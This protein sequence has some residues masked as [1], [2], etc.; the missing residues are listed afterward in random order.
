MAAPNCSQE[1]HGRNLPPWIDL[2]PFV[3]AREQPVQFVPVDHAPRPY[4]A[5]VITQGIRE[6]V[7]RDWQAARDNK[8]AYWA[9]R[10]AHLG[11]LEAFR[12][13]DEVRRMF[14]IYVRVWGHRLV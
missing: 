2:D 14:R 4:K 13:A 5:R 11:P 9:E 7:A 3:V 8:D 12:I 1:P 10:I 6:F